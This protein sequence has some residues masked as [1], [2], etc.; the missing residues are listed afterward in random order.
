MGIGEVYA[1]ICALIWAT[2]IILFKHAG[3]SMSADSLNMIKNW[4]GVFLFVPTAFIIEGAV[5][6]TLTI[7]QW[8]IVALS[9]Y[10]GIAVADGWFLNA[11]R[12]LG[13]ART[14]I[15]ACLYS[16]FVVVL[17]IVFLGERLVWWK[18]GGVLLILVGI[19]LVVYQKEQQKISKEVLTKGILLAAA[20]VFLTAVGVVAMKPIL[21]TDGFF[22]LITIRLFAGAFGLTMFLIFKGELTQ[23]VSVVRYENHKW[24]TIILASIFGTYLAMTFWLAGFKYADASVAS[25][26]NEL[27]NIFIVIMAWLFLKEPFTRQKAFGVLLSFIGVFIFVAI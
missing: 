22:W 1:L 26:L 6:P 10:F 2:A 24:G 14:A 11:L 16:P 8:T 27:S 25:V 20:A 17:S 21:S 18:W 9:G 4:I 12:H 19:L 13:A 5:L 23:L 7:S 15:V 3:N